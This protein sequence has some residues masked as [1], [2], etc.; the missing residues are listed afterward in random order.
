MIHFILTYAIG[1]VIIL[2]V[3]HKWKKELDIDNFDN[4]DDDEY[5]N[6]W[7]S[8][9]QAY[10]VWSLAWPIV[11]PFFVGAMLWKVILTLSIWIQA[12]IDKPTQV[13]IKRFILGDLTIKFVLRHYWE[14]PDPNNIW[15][16]K[17]NF[18]RKELG[19]WYDKNMA[20]GTT[21]K[22]IEAFKESNLYPSYML[23]VNLLYIKFWI[24]VDRKVLHIKLDE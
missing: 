1:F 20:V 10:A 3:L 21:K 6:D 17:Y 12:R 7:D 11:A 18:K 15:T 22:G 23:G 13:F 9:A 16:R 24:T 14:K 5:Y 2:F 8:N 19:F 4:H